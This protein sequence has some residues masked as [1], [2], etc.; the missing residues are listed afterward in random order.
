MAKRTSKSR[1]PRTNGAIA[2]TTADS[3]HEQGSDETQLTADVPALVEVETV[4][5]LLGDTEETGTFAALEVPDEEPADAGVALSSLHRLENDIRDLHTR[6]AAVEGELA[7]RDMEIARLD[8]DRSIQMA[9]FKAMQAE[10]DEGQIRDEELQA[11]LE[12]RN[13]RIDAMLA[14][15]DQ[16]AD[17]IAAKDKLLADGKSKL[18]D[19]QAELG[20]ARQLEQDV[21]GQLQAEREAQQ[22]HRQQVDELKATIA[23]LKVTIN[24]LES[25]I[26]RR[27]AE[28]SQQNADL[29]HYRDALSG[30]EHALQ[31]KTADIERENEEKLELS[32]EIVKLQNRCAELD[33]RRAERELANHE[34]QDRLTGKSAE[35]EALRQD[36][37]AAEQAQVPLRNEADEYAVQLEAARSDSSRLQSELRELRRDTERA[38]KETRANA[39]SEIAAMRATLESALED[40][41]RLQLSMSDSERQVAS[42]KDELEGERQKFQ[43]IWDAAQ[44]AEA[45]LASTA[46]ERNQ[47]T[48][49]LDRVSKQLQQMESEFNQYRNRMEID[50]EASMQRN[51]ELEQELV[52]RKAALSALD[53]NVEMVNKINASVQRLDE[54]ISASAS[55]S[56]GAKGGAGIRRLMVAIHGQKKVRYPLYKDSM[57]I[58]RSPEADIQVRQKWISR[59]HAR[60]VMD[61]NTVRIEDLGS[62][63]GILLNNQPVQA[64]ELHNEDVVEIGDTQ[65]QFIDLMEK[66]GEHAA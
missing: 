34:L 23:E 36:L 35:I 46:E 47:L 10:L 17:E 28:W 60:I 54:Q 31:G 42:L 3:D 55:P 33:G 4:D 20:A 8:E 1:R 43:Q 61:D 26:D 13:E 56:D 37:Q 63:N 18:A 40:A 57:T 65:F 9:A 14:A 50:L 39:D 2:K 24:D 12:A 49:E 32:A 52:E 16:D 53:R 45:R 59:E 11:E 66:P 38:K 25:Y 29:E 27:K 15:A 6:W 62:K 7:A 44:S 48:S 64:G 51:G 30:M 58:G 19:L 5:D 22:G 21:R 41:H